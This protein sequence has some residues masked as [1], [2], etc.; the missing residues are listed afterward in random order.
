MAWDK[1]AK[2]ILG[3]EIA[4][5]L[6]NNEISV[7]SAEQNDNEISI[8]LEFY[9]DLGEDVIIDIDCKDKEDFIKQFN[10][11]AQNFDAEEHAEMWAESKGK[12]G[13]PDSLYE[14]LDDAT[15]IKEFLEQVSQELEGKQKE[16][17]AKIAPPESIDVQI[18]LSQEDLAKIAKIAGIDSPENADFSKI[19]N[20][21]D[22]ENTLHSLVNEKNK[23]IDVNKHQKLL[24]Y[25]HD[26]IEKETF[27][28]MQ[29]ELYPADYNDFI[30]SETI[31]DAFR[32]YNMEA[33][34][35]IPFSTYLYD[36][37]LDTIE[38]NMI[39]LED[40]LLR[41]LHVSVEQNKPEFLSDLDT[42]IQEEGNYGTLEAFGYKGTE[43]DMDK[44]LDNAYKV[45]IQLATESEK[46]SSISLVDQG[47][48]IL[49][50]E[51]KFEKETNDMNIKGVS[52]NALTYLLH[53]QG[54]SFEETVQAMQ[55]STIDE[56]YENPSQFIT[57]VVEELRDNSDWGGQLTALVEMSGTDLVDMLDKVT[58]EDKN[59]ENIVLGENTTMGI[60][61]RSSGSGSNFD[62][63]LDSEAVIPLSMIENIQLESSGRDDFVRQDAN[64]GYTVD[65]TYGFVGSVW[66]DTY[67]GTTDKEP[68][69]LQENMKETF[70][71][72][73]KNEPLKDTPVKEDV[74]L[75]LD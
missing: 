58:S 60:F 61:D 3:E 22:I 43:Y 1:N 71:T 62:I 25:G 49:D 29:G 34:Q 36:Q 30:H 69:L 12:N 64:I 51:G 8:G 10:D 59:K 27:G 50:K 13:V 16:M 6:D 5:I 23:E 37:T 32:E 55:K 44:F 9:S 67:K 4:E 40:N 33:E 73:N 70:E 38:E 26:F 52:D 21:K 53:Q 75:E 46:N 35:K 20:A 63:Q 2:K 74:G 11:Y 56:S 18:T 7:Y 14:L 39:S 72:L 54:H 17:E 19:L 66:T 31:L 24:D 41:S 57:S 15:S 47:F 42:M 28:K 48:N 65:D 45:N 68:E